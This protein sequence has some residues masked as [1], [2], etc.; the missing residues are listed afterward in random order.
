[1]FALACRAGA[2]LG[3]LSTQ[4]LAAYADFGRLFGQLVQVC[5]DYKDTY[6]PGNLS[7]FRVGQAS[8]PVVYGW[9]VAG[10]QAREQIQVLRSQAATN[11]QAAS[12]L[13]QLLDDLGYLLN[14][15]GA[16]S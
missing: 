8:L 2:R 11:A 9:T 3:N 12:Q 14:K 1:M 4:A 6:E 5:D 13:R 10:S 15:P 7:D 16:C